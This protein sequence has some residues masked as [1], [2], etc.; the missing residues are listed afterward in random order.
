MRATL[1][2]RFAEWLEPD[3]KDVA[4]LDEIAGWHLEQAVRHGERLGRGVDPGLAPRAA[5]HLQAAG[6]RARDRGDLAAARSL[7]ERALT[8]ASSAEPFIRAD[9]RCAG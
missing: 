9:Q 6:A 1:H 7:L 5:A 3:C 8:L 4:E 2:E